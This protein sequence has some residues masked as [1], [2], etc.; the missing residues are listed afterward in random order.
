MLRTFAR[1]VITT[2]CVGCCWS[3]GCGTR[4]ATVPDEA[5]TLV[6]RR[7]DEATPPVADG[8]PSNRNSLP[9]D[10]AWM[11]GGELF[12][13]SKAKGRDEPLLIVDPPWP[14]YLEW[15]PD[16]RTLLHARH[17]AGWNVWALHVDTGRTERLTTP[18][19]NRC[20]SWSPDG[21]AFAWQRGGDGLWLWRADGALRL[22]AE[23]HRDHRPSWSPD[24]TSIA[25][26]H[27][28][29]DGI[30]EAWIVP[31]PA[32]RAEGAV[33]SGS[34]RRLRAHA[35][36]PAWSPDG[37][38][39]ACSSW[40]E[41]QRAIVCI[42][43]LGRDS[44]A[45]HV[46]A[47]DAEFLGDPAWSEDSRRLAWVRAND[48]V[49]QLVVTTTGEAPRVLLEFQGRAER[50]QWFPGGDWVLVRTADG[51]VAVRVA[52]GASRSIGGPGAQIAAPRPR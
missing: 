42:D 48:D 15:S 39:I 45:D 20:P 11:R 18:G 28:T 14:R 38:W 30:V 41:G 6:P 32:A 27:V 43:P 4:T 10:V 33:V 31:V 35:A 34:A 21:S 52:D 24:G 1:G 29:E 19:D 12:L 17:D 50:P 49:S 37:R 36:G 13:W 16:G 40:I 22:C 25:F 23:G 5:T 44:V 51:V 7:E 8:L 3:A 47:V 46:V 9:C 26:E 2:V